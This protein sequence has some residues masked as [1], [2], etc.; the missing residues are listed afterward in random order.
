MHPPNMITLGTGPQHVNWPRTRQDMHSIHSKT[1][2]ALSVFSVL[3]CVYPKIS[4][5]S[6]LPSHLLI[7]SLAAFNLQLNPS[8][9]LFQLLYFLVL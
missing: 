1:S 8:S 5:S 9:S 7:L 2:Y 6:G 3:F 4:N